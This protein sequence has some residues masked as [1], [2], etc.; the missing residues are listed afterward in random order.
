MLWFNEYVSKIIQYIT[1]NIF[2]NIFYLDTCTK[3]RTLTS[4][5]GTLK[6][7]TF[8]M[9]TYFQ[10]KRAIV[11]NKVCTTVLLHTSLYHQNQFYELFFVESL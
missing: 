10:K 7:T 2:L 3:L 11:K 1:Q 5:S 9:E 6:F 8:E 4:N